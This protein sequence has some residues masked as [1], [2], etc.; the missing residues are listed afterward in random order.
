MERTTLIAIAL[1]PL[2]AP[3][4]RWVFLTPGR[5]V[6]DALWKRL[7]EGRL[8]RILLKKVG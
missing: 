1:A 8:R 3:L 6:S 7:P 2:L 5:K 4:Y